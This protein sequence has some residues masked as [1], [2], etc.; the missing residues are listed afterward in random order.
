M[1]VS[2]VGGTDAGFFLSRWFIVSLERKYFLAYGK[3]MKCKCGTTTTLTQTILTRVFF[4]LAG[5]KDKRQEQTLLS[6]CGCSSLCYKF[7]KSCLSAT[8]IG[9]VAR[10]RPRCKHTLL[11][12]ALW[13]QTSP[14]SWHG[15]CW[16]SKHT[17]RAWMQSKADRNH[18]QGHRWG[19]AEITHTWVSTQPTASFYQDR[20][21][22]NAPRRPVF[23]WRNW[24]LF[25]SFNYFFFPFKKKINCQPEIS[26]WV[27]EFLWKQLLSSTTWAQQSTLIL[28]Q[29]SILLKAPGE[30]SRHSSCSFGPLPACSSRISTEQKGNWKKG[31][32]QRHTGISF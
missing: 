10:N 32:L 4:H 24:A 30:S 19:L 29:P 28:A 25:R 27:R 23:L 15:W 31:R 20:N 21:S 7:L 2:F 18:S 12:S 6:N 8:G 26:D 11:F 13:L 1:T 16:Y 3:T 22:Y 14:Y 17:K 9:S 5:M